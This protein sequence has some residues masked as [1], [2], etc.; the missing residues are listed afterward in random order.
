MA[1]VMSVPRT[2][3]T[4][5]MG[6]FGQDVD[7]RVAETLMKLR[8]KEQTHVVKERDVRAGASSS[9]ALSYCTS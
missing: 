5:I 3:D 1:K 8:L 6:W 9:E 4:R 7:I 2:N